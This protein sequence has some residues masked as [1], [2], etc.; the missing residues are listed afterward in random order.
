[1]GS[2]RFRVRIEKLASSGWS[3]WGADAVH[4]ECATNVTKADVSVVYSPLDKIASGGELARFMLALKVALDALTR[5]ANG[6]NANLLALAVDAGELQDKAIAVAT[7]LA[8]TAPTA[9]RM[10][11]YVL[12]HYLR[13]NQTILDLSLAFEMAN[14]GSDESEEA[15]RAMDAG[16][17]PRF[18]PPQARFR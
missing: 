9:L 3:E 4:F 6:G 2:T 11:K 18:K 5:G 1:M 16:E 15:M 7:K 14:F 10:S 12:N 8:E 17:S 13:Q